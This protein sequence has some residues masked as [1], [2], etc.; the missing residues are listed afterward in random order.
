MSTPNDVPPFPDL[1][2]FGWVAGVVGVG[3]GGWRLL[4]EWLNGRAN[5]T[6][7]TAETDTARILGDKA[8]IEAR[9]AGVVELANILAAMRIQLENLAA[10]LENERDDNRRF[11]GRVL[12]F[13]AFLMQELQVIGEPSRSRIQSALDELR[14]GTTWIG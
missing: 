2:G 11:R 1:A 6:K 8:M 3:F 4:A 12:A 7:L 9:A 13:V 10:E 14:A 5:R